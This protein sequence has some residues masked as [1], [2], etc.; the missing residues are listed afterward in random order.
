V[1]ALKLMVYL[2]ERE[3]AGG[4]LATDALGSLFARR[5]I[6]LAVLLRGIE[7][8][9][10]KHALQTHRLLTFSEDLPLAWIAIDAPEKIRAVTQEIDPL[11][12]RG[13]VTLERIQVADRPGEVVL[14]EGDAVKLTVYCGRGERSDGA[15]AYHA[16]VDHLRDQGVEG[17]SVLLGV[18]GVRDGIRRRPRLVGRNP[19]VPVMILAL[20]TRY[21]LAAALPGLDR[22][23]DHPVITLER[24]R[25]LK[26]DGV[27][28]A[29]L[30]P[31]RDTDPAGL[32]LWQKLTVH[33]A[34]D[35]QAPGGRGPLYAE[36]LRELRR[37]GA[38]GGTVLGGVW[39]YSG[40]RPPHGDHVLSLRR[41]VPVVCVCMERP[42]RMA[43]LWPV[44]DRMTV[45]SGLVTAELV[46][47]FRAAGP[48]TR[49]GGLELAEGR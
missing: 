19:G 11:L 16:A 43:E 30:L 28:R 18:D 24:A 10:V 45:R 33:T 47:A 38:S 40:T 37:A 44:I 48:G 35:T 25:L 31:T 46:P 22:L 49:I 36:L 23:L 41:S 39:G 15:L 3:R 1:N 29:P 21:R 14:H 9:G 4:L 20:G 26:Q 2:G 6:R 7:G 34:S 13:L 42:Q 27:A 5:G 32:G 12:P 8:F 17:A